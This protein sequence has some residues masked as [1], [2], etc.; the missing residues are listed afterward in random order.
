MT[1]NRARSV[2]ADPASVSDTP[3]PSIRRLRSS[4]EQVAIA[5]PRQRRCL[6]YQ[7]ANAGAKRIRA[8]VQSSRIRSLP[9]S[10]SFRSPA[11][12]WR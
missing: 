9:R 1:G 2:A 12:W 10:P 11:T 4:L 6:A 8:V 3:D 5:A 7:A